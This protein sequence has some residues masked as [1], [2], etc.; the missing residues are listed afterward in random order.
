MQRNFV[1]SA[2]MVCSQLLCIVLVSLLSYCFILRRS[3]AGYYNYS[4]H[5]LP[6]LRVLDSAEGCIEVATQ[7]PIGHFLPQGAECFLS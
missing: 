7:R 4:E 1:Q 6:A 3:F 5:D 2:E